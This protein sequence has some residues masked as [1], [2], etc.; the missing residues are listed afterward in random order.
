M[1]KGAKRVVKKQR[2][3][4][5]DYLRIFEEKINSKDEIITNSPFNLSLYFNDISEIEVKKRVKNY[6][7]E[8]IRLQSIEKIQEP[9]DNLK[10]CKDL[11][12]LHFIRI[13]TNSISGIATPDGE[14]DE[15]LLTEK[16]D[17]NQYLAES[18]ACLYD[19]EKN[20]FVIARNRDAV[21]PSA[22]LEFFKKILN[23]QHLN[24]AILPNN[25]NLKSKKSCIYRKLVIGMK[26]MSTLNDKDKSY[27]KV[28][29]PAVYNAINGFDGYGYCNIKIELTMGDEPKNISM[30][31]QLVKKTGYKLMESGIENLNK[32]EISSK[33]NADTKVETIDL[34]NNKIKDKFTVGYSRSEPILYADVI[35]KLL[36]SYNIK[37]KKTD[38]I[39]K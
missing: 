29:I 37:K 33:E 5:V 9:T 17:D 3:F 36:T 15:K 1:K 38:G 18:T 12:E 2:E 4:Q 7:N 32:V 27:L 22:I 14:Y 13:K 25:T 23:N 34:I 19:G 6:N 28:N 16:L 8:V 30:N 11:W 20:L 31:N 35:I 21:L 10:K 39:I 24:Y 26:D